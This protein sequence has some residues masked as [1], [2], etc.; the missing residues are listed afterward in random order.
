MNGAEGSM[1]PV[2]TERKAKLTSV[3]PVSSWL[4]VVEFK[5]MVISIMSATSGEKKPW[6]NCVT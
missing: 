6:I 3:L 2:S 5:Y 1:E 4:Y